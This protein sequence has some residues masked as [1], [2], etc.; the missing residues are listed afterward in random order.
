VLDGVYLR[1]ADGTPGFV[2]APAP[3]DEALQAVLLAVPTSIS[4][5][6]SEGLTNTLTPALP[7]PMCFRAT[8]AAM[9]PS[10]P[11]STAKVWA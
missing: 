8:T 5:P 1:S 2:E 3:S 9:V 4:A 10:A 11:S 6:A 7:L